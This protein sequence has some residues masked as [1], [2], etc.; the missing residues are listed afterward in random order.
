MRSP[1]YLLKSTSTLTKGSSKFSKDS[2]KEKQC[3][4]N[5]NN[6]MVN[7]VIC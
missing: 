1:F 4:V 7:V 6:D 2:L 3:M 5:I